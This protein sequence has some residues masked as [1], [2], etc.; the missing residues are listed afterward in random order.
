MTQTSS[1]VRGLESEIEKRD[2]T[3]LYQ[4]R[5]DNGDVN[6]S[7]Q[8]SNP[9]IEKTAAAAG[10][11]RIHNETNQ[12]TVITTNTYIYINNPDNYD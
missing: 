4:S 9:E 12:G 2:K 3:L 10:E 6:Y 11:G 8:N 1:H 7:R 5:M